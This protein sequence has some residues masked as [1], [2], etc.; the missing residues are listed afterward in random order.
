MKKHNRLMLFAAIFSVAI[1]SCK[2]ELEIQN[3]TAFDLNKFEQNIRDTYGP[4][5]TG[6]S[7][8]IAVGDKIVKNGAMGKARING[9]G[10]IDYS[11]ET[12]QH[13]CSVSKLVTAIAVCSTLKMMNK[14]LEEKVIKYLP[15]SWVIDSSYKDLSFRQLLSH[16]SGFTV[17]S[18]FYNTLK[19]MISQPRGDTSPKYNNS[20]FTLCRILLPCMYFGTNWIE[21]QP[22]TVENTTAILFRTLTRELVLKPAGLTYWNLADFKDWTHVNPS[23]YRAPRY[24]VMDNLNL[25]SVEY[26]DYLLQ[27]GAGGLVLSTYEMAQ[28]LVALENEQLL[29]KSWTDQMK[30]NG[31]GFD[32]TGV[33]GSHG[34]YYA[35]NGGLQDVS[36]RGAESM[37]MI[38]PNKIMVSISCNSN[39]S[40]NDQLVGNFSL[41]AQLF[42]QSFVVQ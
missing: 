31:C 11:I 41:I 4:Q 13:L 34:K 18:D 40:Y 10:D 15:T 26:G 32:G 23:G 20:N 2:K 27:S 16:K 35:K 38:F 39:R 6:F 25:P 14:T 24:Y 17:Q 42:D 9:D 12:R 8:S 7:Y 36:G 37:V 28:V 29:P 1:V 30:Q 22:G 33:S 19:D 3:P 21:Q 5:T